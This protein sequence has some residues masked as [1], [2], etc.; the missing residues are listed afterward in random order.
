[1]AAARRKAQAAPAVVAGQAAA[2]RAEVSG[3]VPPTDPASA[4]FFDI[5]NTI[6]R[7]ASIYHLARGLAKRHF[8]TAR[9]VATFAWQQVK[10]RVQGQED[11]EDMDSAVDH[12]LSFVAGHTVAE[13]NRLGEEIFDERISDRLYPGT[14]ALAGAHIEAGRRV[15]LVSAAPIELA[16][17]IARRLGLTGALAT[18]SEI[19]DGV[20]TGRLRGA[21]LHGA[22]KAEAVLALAEREGLD[23]DA[24]WAYSD[25]SNDIPLLSSVGNPVAIN[26]D[27]ALRRHA[28]AMGWTIHDYRTGRKAAKIGV[29]T[30]LAVGVAAGIAGGLVADQRRRAAG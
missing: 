22:A 11:M 20:Y 15:W 5:D 28:R 29:P 14:V 27:R 9:D 8:F 25:S 10:F 30:A 2:A 21:P 4:A 17:I 18:V 23:L 1:M 24:C 19:Y 16:T 26:P 7:G 3:P 6:V 13:I 12:A